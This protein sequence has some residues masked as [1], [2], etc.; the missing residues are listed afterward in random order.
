MCVYIYICVYVC[1]VF[2][3]LVRLQGSGLFVAVCG[4]EGMFRNQGSAVLQLF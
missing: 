1:V 3:V 4:R 2:V